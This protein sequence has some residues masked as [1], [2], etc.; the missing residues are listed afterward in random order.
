MERRG[1]GLFGRQA[2]NSM[3]YLQVTRVP[4]QDSNLRSRLRRPVT[5]LITGALSTHRLPLSRHE[6]QLFPCRTGVR[7]TNRSTRTD[8]V[9]AGLF[10]EPATPA[11]PAPFHRRR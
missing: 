9:G 7:P 2:D 8:R 4:R 5:Q 6:R 11:P 1:M 3:S 10:L